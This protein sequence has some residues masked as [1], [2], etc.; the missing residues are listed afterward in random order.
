MLQNG[1]S[2]GFGQKTSIAELTVVHNLTP[3]VVEYGKSSLIFYP[4]SCRMD[5]R[6]TSECN[7]VSFLLLADAMLHHVILILSAVLHLSLI[8]I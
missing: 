6:F 2:P 8:H 7:A 1:R 5:S 3:R 4:R